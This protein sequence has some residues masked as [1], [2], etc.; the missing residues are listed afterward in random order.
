VDRRE[1]WAWQGPLAD[2]LKMHDNKRQE[3]FRRAQREIRSGHQ[4]QPE[5]RK[6]DQNY[7][8]HYRDPGPSGSSIHEGTGDER[9]LPPEQEGQ[10]TEDRA[11]QQ[12]DWRRET[13]RFIAGET[14]SY[15]SH[16]QAGC[17]VDGDRSMLVDRRQTWRAREFRQ[18][19]Q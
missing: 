8:R 1:R 16:A 9:P 19:S 17:A 13:H 15:H 7:Q 5:E 10:Q 6:A 18:S 4:E 14:F 3:H 2:A 11:R 12:L